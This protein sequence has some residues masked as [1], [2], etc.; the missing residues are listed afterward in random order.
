M[1]VDSFRYSRRRRRLVAI[2]AR[3]ARRIV[4]SPM[5]DLAL[6]ALHHQ[7]ARRVEAGDV[8]GRLVRGEVN[9]LDRHA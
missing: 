8:L 1:R 3:A 4:E 5:L 7:A 6:P 2:V 9:I